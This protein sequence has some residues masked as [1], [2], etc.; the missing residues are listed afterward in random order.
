[1]AKRTFALFLLVVFLVGAAGAASFRQVVRRLRDVKPPPGM[2]LVPAGNFW[3]GR[4]PDPDPNS[5]IHVGARPLRE[6]SLPSFFVDVHE[7]TVADYRPCLDAGRCMRPAT[8]PDCIFWAPGFDEHPVN[9][10]K[11]QDAVAYCAFVGKRVPTEAEWEKAARGVDGRGY[12][13]GDEFDPAY[14]NFADGGAVDGFVKTA[15]VGSFPQGRSPY[16]VE[17]MAGNLWEWTTTRKK[18]FYDPDR[19]DVLGEQYAG[20][21]RI[22]KGGAFTVKRP[23]LARASAVDWSRQT[24]HSLDLGF[25]CIKP[26]WP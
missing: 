18:T 13:W 10:V 2:V 19:P 1:M 5:D 25:R 12:P 14:G 17:D 24:R 15:P 26:T 7:V 21:S 11:L 4:N 22:I 6:I 16:G 20:E 3:M 9:C 8:G 23:F